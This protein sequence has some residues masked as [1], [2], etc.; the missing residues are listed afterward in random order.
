MTNFDDFSKRYQDHTKAVAEANVLN[1]AAVF[2]ALVAAEVTRVTAE[3]DGEGDSGQLNDIAAYSGETR[4]TLPLTSI[5]LHQARLNT[6]GLTTH[7]ATLKNAV[8]TLSYD[9]LEQEYAGWE[10]N[11]G[12]YGEFIFDVAAREIHLEMNV[13]FSD[14]TQHNHTF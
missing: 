2:D 7:T 12:A 13:R 10:N 14:T 11:D 3:F 9:Y 6:N 1:K 4:V 5:T 8:E